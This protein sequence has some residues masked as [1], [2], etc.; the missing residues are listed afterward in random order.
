MITRD[1]LQTEKTPYELLALDRRAGDEAVKQAFSRAIAASK[2]RRGDLRKLREAR[3]T[4]FRPVQR[5]LLDILLYDPKVVSRLSPTY[6]TDGSF[7]GLGARQATAKAWT[8]HLRA[9]FPDLPTIHSLAVLWYW[10]ATHEG[11][12]FAAL[13]EALSESGVPAR[14]VTTKRRLLQNISASEARTCRPGPGA[15][16][17]DPDC[18]WHDE[19]SYTCPPIDVIW[20]KAI[21]YWSVLIASHKFWT[22][23]AG[24]SPSVAGEARE[25]M[26]NAL[27]EPLF[28]LRERFER[29]SAPRL[30]SLF[31]Q[32][33]IDL[34]TELQAAHDMIRAGASL[35]GPNADGVGC[36]RLL[37]K[38]VDQLEA[39]R[40]KVDARLRASGENGHLQG[41]KLGL[42]AYADVAQ[43]LTRDRWDDALAQLEKL[44]QAEQD[45]AEVRRL[46]AKALI[47]KGHQEAS[48]G[49][50]SAA[51]KSWHSALQVTDDHELREEATTA[52]VSSCL[53]RAATLGKRQTDE[54]ISILEEGR[55]LV[56]SRNLDLRLAD[57]LCDQAVTIFN[58]T[59][60]KI[61][62]RQGP[63][64][65]SD[66]RA[67]EKGLALL[68]RAGPLGSDRARG[69]IATA[70]QVLEAVKQ[71]RKPPQPPQW[72]EWVKKA[73]DAAG[74]DD[75]DTAITYL[76][77]VLSAAGT[78]AP[79]T[80][81]KNLATCLANRA[82]G[83][84]NTAIKRGRLNLAILRRAE[85]DLAEAGRLDPTSEHIWTNKSTVDTLL[86]QRGLLKKGS[87]WGIGSLLVGL[88]A[89]A[90]AEYALFGLLFFGA[91]LS[92]VGV[93]LARFGLR[94]D[95]R[96]GWAMV[97][98]LLSIA[99]VI[100]YAYRAYW[101]EGWPALAGFVALFVFIVFIVKKQN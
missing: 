73:N 98:G 82:I 83:Q 69:Q 81:K 22:E 67:L 59:Q 13:A 88:L 66:I 74:R 5:A 1:P 34:S 77:R 93:K 96:R 16:C 14:T 37:L 95:S 85:K 71:A 54:A 63:P 7:L 4:L 43:L 23:Q 76:R 26:D 86:Q 78:E 18:R 40:R 57:L 47:A 90:Y 21:A 100:L 28:K 41:L 6:E 92:C 31:R 39:V 29:A 25:A 20:R 49:D 60:E 24:L 19:C 30:A 101:Q 45:S 3:S 94:R 72:M 44:P 61:K 84:V 50:V 15:L 11:E 53:A 17:P 52:I 58:E 62:A 91:L 55:R 48:V 42:T 32:L 56:T 75:W 10:W 79:A 38:E 87:G 89:W 99:G 27:R 33:E 70:Q 51:L 65:A 68:E 36:G 9:H 8:T 46:N 64:T 80:L 35:L 97:G 2:G 12:R